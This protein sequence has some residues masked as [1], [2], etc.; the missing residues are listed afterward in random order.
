MN[1][2]VCPLCG[3][4]PRLDAENGRIL[5]DHC[6]L[7]LEQPNVE[8]L[9]ERWEKRPVLFNVI[10]RLE[11]MMNQ[12]CTLRRLDDH[13]WVLLDCD[14]QRTLARGDDLTH[15]CHVILLEGLGKA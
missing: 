4:K 12:G 10:E 7:T 1:L 2:S 13:G 11:R 14:G 5:C 3:R 6:N 9:V 8:E 15:L